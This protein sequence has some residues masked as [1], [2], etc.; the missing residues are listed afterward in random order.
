MWI[1]ILN[2]FVDLLLIIAIAINYRSRAKVKQRI[3][4]LEF[5]LACKDLSDQIGDLRNDP[6]FVNGS[7]E[8]RL[9]RIT[10]ITPID[11]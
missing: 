1:T 2:L 9:K 4:D 8:Y 7:R 3:L 11:D 6:N 5:Q 10:D